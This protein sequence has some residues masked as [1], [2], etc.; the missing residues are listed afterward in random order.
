MKREASSPSLMKMAE[1]YSW[2]WGQEDE[3]D[4]IVQVTC[5]SPAR[6]NAQSTCR[7][8]QGHNVHFNTLLQT[9]HRVAINFIDRACALVRLRVPV[10][11]AMAFGMAR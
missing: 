10:A 7:A 11:R 2:P 8:R 3:F 6:D 4:L 5:E 9:T 1:S